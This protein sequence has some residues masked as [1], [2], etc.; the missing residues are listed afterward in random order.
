[1]EA[2]WTRH[3]ITKEYAEQLEKDYPKKNG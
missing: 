3:K 2:F 1:M